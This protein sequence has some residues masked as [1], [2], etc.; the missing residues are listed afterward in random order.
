MWKPPEDQVESDTGWRP[1]QDQIVSQQQMGGKPPLGFV[2]KQ[3]LDL[4]PM[5]H[6][7]ENLPTKGA[8][9]GTA[10]GGPLAGAAGAGIGQIASRMVDIWSGNVP[11]GDA[12][13]PV[14]EAIAPMVQTAVGGIPDASGITSPGERTIGQSI[15][16]GLAK[17]GQAFSGARADTLEQAAKQGYSTYS[18]PSLQKAK[19][20]FSSVLGPE[21]QAAMK[22]TA[23]QSFDPALGS[24][25]SLATDIGTKLESGESISAID[26]LKARQATDRVISATPLWD[27]KARASLFDWRNAFDDV[28]KTQ[29]GPLKE[30]ST[31]YRKAVVK[32]ALLKLLPV[33]KHGEY[34]RLAPMLASIA[35]GVGG[36]SGH[37]TKGGIIGTAGYLGAT[38]PLAMGLAATTLGSISPQMRQ[39]A[40]ASFIDKFTTK[41]NSN[42]R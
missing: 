19:E 39:A 32:D 21:G 26:A 33:N 9:L 40:L 31:I 27:T 37:S 29:N 14:K 20:V 11:A 36:V 30:A 8:I 42:A 7:F 24:A 3:V 4:S 35:G 16:K 25:R 6:P 15:G 41:D 13:N 38:S 23:A 2:V 18:A 12:M 17:V 1:P 34:S 5:G 10:L 22:Q 28:I